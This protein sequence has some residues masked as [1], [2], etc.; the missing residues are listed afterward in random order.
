MLY[1]AGTKFLSRLCGGEVGDDFSDIYDI[2]LSRLCGGEDQKTANVL[3][4]IFLS[5][6]CGGEGNCCW[7]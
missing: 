5:R 2:F 1:I 4:A 6:L 3:H 7:R